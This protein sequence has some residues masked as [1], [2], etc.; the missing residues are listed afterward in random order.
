MTTEQ[1]KADYY[2]EKIYENI[3]ETEFN[4]K[5]TIKRKSDDAFITGLKTKI[6][7][8]EVGQDIADSKFE[9]NTIDW[10]AYLDATIIMQFNLLM[11]K[12]NLI[13]IYNT[14]GKKNIADFFEENPFHK[15]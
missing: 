11:L 6:N 4:C 12:I 8:L 1:F 10:E 15:D 13:D 5:L 3:S 9:I 7:V 14:D 2:L